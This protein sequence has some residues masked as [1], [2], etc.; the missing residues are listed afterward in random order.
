MDD[1]LKQQMR[2]ATKSLSGFSAWILGEDGRTPIET[3]IVGF[4]EWSSQNS[5]ELSYRVG[6]DELSDATV[7][8][9]FLSQ[10]WDRRRT[11]LLFETMVFGVDGE[12]MGKRNYATW[13]EA[14]QGH[15]ELVSKLTRSRK[16]APVT[17][18][19]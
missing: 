8:T 18:K 19:P 11:P 13:D 4:I 12:V 5:G 10:L 6:L 17:P 15:A 14:E 1:L 7:S 3:D 2:E 16:A 9:V